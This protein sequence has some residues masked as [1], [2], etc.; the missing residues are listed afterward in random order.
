MRT[1]KREE[2]VLQQPNKVS[3]FD[4]YFMMPFSEDSQ[5]GLPKPAT[6]LTPNRNCRLDPH[7]QGIVSIIKSS[8]V[9]KVKGDR[10]V[11]PVFWETHF[12]VQAKLGDT[13]GNS[14]VVSINLYCFCMNPTWSKN[15]AVEYVKEWLQ[16]P[17]AFEFR[18]FVYGERAAARALP[19]SL[20]ALAPP[21]PPSPY[22][23]PEEEH[24]VQTPGVQIQELPEDI[25]EWH[26]AFQDMKRARL[27]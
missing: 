22:E 27:I 15:P 20:P 26:E 3:G 10:K 23:L 6:Y 19:P 7:L 2:V 14:C 9:P 12:D 21:S 11:R 5:F 16:S 25:S 4:W 1:P 18:G 13:H 24:E 8:E 17:G